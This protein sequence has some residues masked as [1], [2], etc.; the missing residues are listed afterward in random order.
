MATFAIFIL[1]LFVSVLTFTAA[2]LVGLQEASDS[3]LS[4]AEHLAEFE[5]KIV[6]RDKNE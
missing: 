4:K 6:G 3:S 2:L 1:G 5:K